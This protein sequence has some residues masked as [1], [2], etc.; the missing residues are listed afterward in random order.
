MST[1]PYTYA[2]GEQWPEETPAEGPV[3]SS[4]RRAANAL[5]LR[6]KRA[7]TDPTWRDRSEESKRVLLDA[8]AGDE[9]EAARRDRERK[10]R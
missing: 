7:K 8:D 5:T 2:S 4:P 6:A 1:E 9:A 10:Q 3:S